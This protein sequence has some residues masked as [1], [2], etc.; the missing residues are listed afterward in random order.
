MGNE[1]QVLIEGKLGVE[2]GIV[3]GSMEMTNAAL[4]YQLFYIN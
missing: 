4:E 3:L 1:K 2:Y